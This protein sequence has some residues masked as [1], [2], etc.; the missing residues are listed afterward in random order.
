MA[1]Y[2]ND[3]PLYYK[4]TAMKCLMKT[5]HS[6]KKE[7]RWIGKCM[8]KYCQNTAKLFSGTLYVQ[9]IATCLLMTEEN[10]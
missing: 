9:L 5:K 10:I 2:L 1:E 3:P 7:Y 8:D 4:G 6:P